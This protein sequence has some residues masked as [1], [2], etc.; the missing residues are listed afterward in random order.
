MNFQKDVIAT[1]DLKAEQELR[2]EVDWTEKVQLKMIRGRAEIF[3]NEIALEVPYT[4]TGGSKLAV[5]T[6][7]G[8]SIEI[9]GNLK[10]A[11]VSSETPM[12]TYINIHLILEEL[13]QSALD[14]G[15][16]GP[17]VMVVGP[18]DSGKTSLCKILLNYGL[19]REWKPIFVD[20]DSSGGT[21]IAPTTI[22]AVAIDRPDVEESFGF[23]LVT[24]PPLLYYYGENS[25]GK[26]PVLYNQTVSTLAEVVLK[27]LETDSDLTASGL[28]I[29]THSWSEALGYDTYFHAVEAFQVDTILVV[30]SERLHSDFVNKFKDYPRK[31][32]VVKVA[33]SGGVVTREPLFR[34]QMQMKKVKEYFYGTSS[35]ELSPYTTSIPFSEIA[36]RRIG[37]GRLLEIAYVLTICSISS[38]V[39]CITSRYGKTSA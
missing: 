20:L 38:S 34:K 39:L 36:V 17:R 23:S 26:N 25:P 15:K 29:D 6:W 12:V 16:I 7:H 32:N 35:H 8:C 28:I 30:G 21:L 1:F 18:P 22:G 11:Y 4:F 14:N 19:K 9:R 3:G 37:E 5:F 31:V 13:R 27:R 24:S 10:V 2:F 33:K